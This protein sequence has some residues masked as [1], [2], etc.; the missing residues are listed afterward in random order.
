MKYENF[1][2]ATKIV[3]QIREHEKTLELINSEPIVILKRPYRDESMSID[4]GY[5][6]EIDRGCFAI[7][8]V[9]VL[10]KDTEKRIE[11]LKMMLLI[12]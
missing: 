11:T 6:N 4:T 2:Q 8:F 9:D 12:L 7:D 10:R 5:K 3:E 1:E